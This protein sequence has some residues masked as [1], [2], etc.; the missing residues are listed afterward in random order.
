MQ[1]YANDFGI[2]ARLEEAVLVFLQ[3]HR[4]EFHTEFALPQDFPNINENTEPN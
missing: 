3:D 1:N 2:T 4:E